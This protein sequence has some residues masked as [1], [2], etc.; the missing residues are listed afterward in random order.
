[1]FDALESFD[2]EHNGRKFRAE[3]FYDEHADS[4]WD[5]GDGHGPVSDFERRGKAPGELVL[6]GDG[7]GRLGTDAARRFYD[8]EEACRVARRDGWG[9][10]PGPLTIETADAGRAPY[11]RRGGSAR[12]DAAGLSFTDS[13]DVNRAI[14][15]VY[16]AVR[17][18]LSPREYAARAARAD[19]E[20]LR[21]WCNGEWSYVGVRVAA[22]CP[23][24]G[25]A[26]ESDA[27]S[28]WGIESDSGDYLREVARELS[29]EIE[30][31]ESEDCDENK[32]A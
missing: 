11:Q 13:E 7:R 25:E 2:F 1:M 20:R 31:A 15:A 18:S 29:E 14:H 4:P 27:E 26:R 21:A 32:E 22:L 23:C 5:F 28:L 16:A 24:C 9:W 10:L 12:C 3:I 17:E 8:F 19:F 6:C 30:T